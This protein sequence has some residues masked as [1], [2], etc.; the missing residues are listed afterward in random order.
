LRA[1]YSFQK[2]PIGPQTGITNYIDRDRHTMAVGAGWAIDKPVSFLPGDL[3]F[4]VH[5]QFNVLP[6]AVTMKSNPA[7]FVGDY[8]AG[9]FIWNL[10]A[11]MLVG[12]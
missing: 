3:R 8:S 1:G 9:G 5:A 2:S 10:G 6:D 4:D 7:D 11:T 12:F